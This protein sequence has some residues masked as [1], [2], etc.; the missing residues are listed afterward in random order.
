M[1]AASTSSRCQGN[2]PVS[3]V[4]QR[5]WRMPPARVLR[6]RSQALVEVGKLNHEPVPPP[7]GFRPAVVPGSRTKPTPLLTPD[8]M[9]QRLRS[10]M[11]DYGQENFGAFY[12]S[13]MGGIVVDPALMMLP[14]D[15]QFVCKGYGVS[16]TVVLRDGHLYM[17]DEHIARLTAACAQVGLSLPF[18]VPAVKRI[19]LDTAA[20]SGKLNGQLRFWVTPGRGGFSPV[21]LG[22]SEPA[23]YVI[24]LGD[25]YEIDRTESWDA[26]LAEEPIQA[27][28]VSNVLGNQRLLT[29]VGQVEAHARDAHVAL[30][31]DAE[32][33]VQHCAGYTVCILTQQDTLVY[34]PFES[35]APS[36]TLS[37]ILELIPEERIRSPD[38]VVVA[39]V[40]QR[41][42]HVSE[43]LAAKE[44]F[45]VCTTFTIIPLCSV[46]GK[47]IADNKTGLT[48][49]ALHYMLDNDMQ[50]PPAGVY[51]CRHTPVPYGYTTGMR[52]QLV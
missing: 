28:A 5:G 23:L 47:A 17:L 36:V 51:S 44:C 14:V 33:F 49:L 21:E 2:G 52:T 19:V 13:I 38:D 27:T 15:D 1:E 29:T 6:L 37:R 18:S 24:C 16:E 43:V 4:G 11:H 8:V 12:S 9:V 46:D 41:K 10:S 30:F 40:Q 39:N 20:A 7:K 32:G 26:I 25:T 31:T 35:T 48:T 3:R 45:L 34:P 22:G 42:L 50:P